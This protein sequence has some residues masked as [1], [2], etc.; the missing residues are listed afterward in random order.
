MNSGLEAFCLHREHLFES[1]NC[2]CVLP[3]HLH[4][5]SK[6]RFQTP[7]ESVSCFEGITPDTL[8]LDKF[9]LFDYLL[10]SLSL[11]LLIRRIRKVDS[12]KLRNDV[13]FQH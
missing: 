11:H 6:E 5:Q 7:E 12:V 3:F 13:G 9:N 2:Q 8:N 1:L 4:S 10:K